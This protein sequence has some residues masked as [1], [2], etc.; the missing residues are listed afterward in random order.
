MPADAPPVRSRSRRVLR[1]VLI[2]I[3]LLTLAAGINTV[4]GGWA[5]AQDAQ[6]TQDLTQQQL[7]SRG[8]DVF[9]AQCA[10]C[11]GETGRGGN[12]APSLIG[13]GPAS[14][15]FMIRTGRMPARHIKPQYAHGP[16]RLSDSD[17]RAVV[18]YV[19][20]LAPNQGPDIPE[21]SGWE[22][23]DLSRGLELF[24]SNCAACHGP[25]AA[26]IAV[27]QQN[28]SS[29]LNQA[30]PLEIAEAMRS[31]PGVMPVFGED[32]IGQHD[33]ESVVAWV[34]NLRQRAAPGGAQIG[35]SGPVTEGFVAW[36][37]GLGTLTIVMYLLGQKST[38]DNDVDH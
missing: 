8:R 28:V 7:V 30:T 16:Q 12:D 3:G 14:V 38:G 11:H 6:G 21:V 13:V 37:L 24:T 29:T 18:A 19:A 10:M 26:G 5:S 1:V 22:H 34:M 35:R 27:G 2:A 9:G 31:G 33:M 23:A 25:T 17:R 36:L 4:F 15:D 32:A 20:S